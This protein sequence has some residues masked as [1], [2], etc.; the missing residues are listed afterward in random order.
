M[1]RGPRGRAALRREHRSRPPRDR[2]DGEDRHAGAGRARRDRVRERPRELRVGRAPREERAPSP[3]RPEVRRDRQREHLRL[4]G[5]RR[6]GALR[7]AVRRLPRRDQAAVSGDHDDRRRRRAASDGDR[8]RALLRV[9]RVVLAQRGSVRRLRPEGTPGVRR[10]VRG[11]P[12]RGGGA[13]QGQPRRRARR[14][15]VHD[16]LRAQPRRGGDV[17]VRAPAHQR[18]QPAVEPRRDRLRRR[19]ELRDAVVPRPAPLRTPPARRGDADDDG[20]GRACPRGDR[21]H[22]RA[23]DLAHPGALLGREAHRGREARAARRV[24]GR[25]GDLGGERRH[26]DPERPGRGRADARLRARPEGRAGVHA[27]AHRAQA[28]GRRGLHRHARPEGRL[29]APVEPRRLGEHEDGLPAR[30]GDRRE[31]AQG[32]DRDRARLPGSHRA[33]GGH[34]AGLPRRR[35]RR[36]ARRDRAPRLRRLVGRG[37]QGPRARR[38]GRQRRGDSARG[39]ARPHGRE[40]RAARARDRALGPVA[41][42]G[43]L[44]RE[45]RRGDDARAPGDRGRPPNGPTPSPPTRSPFCASG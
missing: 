45:A 22:R 42:G 39:D 24:E 5:S 30:R 9:A 1:V 3:L 27:R 32:P 14:G 20:R 8:G 29:G 38:E 7:R 36:D 41:R 33:R 34:D 23:P 31:R 43:E 40:S 37:P 21:G 2:A 17:L 6:R 16:G 10:R 26:A 13:H 12:G 18:E 25:A 44:L 11:D 35:A 19:A 28:R 4:G 15:G